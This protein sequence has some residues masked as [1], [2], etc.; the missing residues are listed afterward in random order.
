M[1]E[2]DSAR[3]INAGMHGES[4]SGSI[5]L[6]PQDLGF[7]DLGVGQSA[8]R[9][10][11]AVTVEA[12]QSLELSVAVDFS[13]RA[14]KHSVRL[15]AKVLRPRDTNW[16]ELEFLTPYSILSISDPEKLKGAARRSRS[17]AKAIEPRRR[18]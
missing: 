13:D 4:H 18:S 9:Q 6:E 11:K 2:G 10:I 16:A 7:G 15:T 3:D 5:L 14:G 12:T 1:T 8:I 17:F